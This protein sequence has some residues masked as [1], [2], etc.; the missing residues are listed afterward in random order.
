[1]GVFFSADS[2]LGI[3]SPMTVPK[4]LR[5]L[6]VFTGGFAFFYIAILGLNTISKAVSKIII[7]FPC[8]LIVADWC[9]NFIRFL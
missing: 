1:M 6:M 7:P 5:L 3:L 2:S 9:A 8:C 4:L